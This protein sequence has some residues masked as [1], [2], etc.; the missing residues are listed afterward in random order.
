M[1]PNSYISLPFPDMRLPKNVPG[2][3]SLLKKLNVSFTFETRNGGLYL[4]NANAMMQS[5]YPGPYI[6]EEYYN[7]KLK[8]FDLKLTFADPKEETMWLL[9]YG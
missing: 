7:S 4:K 6:V 5:L 1:N 3:K 9:K 8:H 2:W